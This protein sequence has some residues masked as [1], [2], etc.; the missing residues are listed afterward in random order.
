MK[1][2]VIRL[3]QKALE[4]ND[5]S[6]KKQE[7]ESLL[8][9]P[10]SYDIGDYAFPCFSLAKIL[11]R[12][13]S[14][15]AVMIRK[16]IK[17]YPETELQDIVVEGPYIN[18][19]FNRKEFA[20]KIVWEAIND[21]QKYGKKN[22]GHGK[23]VVI[24][25]SAPNIAKPFGIGHLRSTI[26]GN[27]LANIHEFLNFKVLR[28]NY[29]GDWGTPLGKVLLGYKLFGDEKKLTK[30][31]IRHLYDLYVRI[32]KNEKYDAQAR[33]WFRKLE[34]EE[35][36]ARTLW[37]RFR[38][39]SIG[40]FDQLY[41]YLGVKFD[42]TSG[43]SLYRKNKMDKIFKELKS[44]GLLEESD[45]ALIIDLKK[46]NLGVSVIKKSDGTLLYITRDL[47]AAIDRFRKYHFSK[48]IYEVGQEQKHHFSQLFKILDL[49]GYKFA[50]NCFHVDHGLYL[51]KDGKKFSTR[52]GKQVF[53]ED[54]IND[55]VGIAKKEIKK[56]NKKISK[57]ELEKRAK[58][59][60]L[61]AILY[62]DLKNNRSN[63]MVFDIENMVNFDGNT[64]PYILYS[65]ARASSI[66]RK[67]EK[68]PVR[69]K[70]YDLEKKEYEFIRELL[71]FSDVVQKAAE[72]MNPSLVANF[73]YSIAQM[74]NEFYHTCPVIGTLEESF[75]LALVEAFRQVLRN[76][77]HL[78][79]IETLEEM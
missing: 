52:K 32:S 43:E 9:V 79:G 20:R 68:R 40:D 56:R 70:I 26:I 64:G 37:R 15:I 48:M 57:N 76:A 10:P 61:A 51:D 24:E 58:T 1:N 75:R 63:N 13:P 30:D 59:I 49:M 50:K 41:K 74:F 17:E 60:G 72:T 22:V 46:Y 8:E 16:E 54:I 7:I 39:R 29:Y 3:L 21:R 34:D 77:L 38:E 42:I 6:M 62:G 44:K 73:C 4:E 27:A 78:L 47:A 5:I 11:K 66:L 45:N 2:S 23:K 25:Y 55:V 65:Y 14:E 53:M 67:A 71:K 28:L 18:F 12:D 36:E 35:V 31:P 33:E 69:F 19:V